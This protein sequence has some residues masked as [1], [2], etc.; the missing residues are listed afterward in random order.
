MAKLTVL[1]T[2]SGAP[3][4]G[5]ACSSYLLEQDGARILLDAG[6]GSLANLRSV[7]EV[8]DID[9]VFITHMHSDHFLDLLPFNVARATAPGQRMTGGAPW[10]TP[11][12]LPP[13]GMATL[14]ACFKALQVNVGGSTAGRW[15][16]IFDTR[17]YDPTETISIGDIDVSF[18]GPTKHAQEDYGF[19]LQLGNGVF[20]YTG[21]TAYCE[22]AI[23][24]GRDAGIFLAECTVLEPGTRVAETHTSVPELAAMANA[25]G[26]ERLLV[27]H[28]SDATENFLQDLEHRLKPLYKKPFTVLRPGDTFEF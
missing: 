3:H 22:A 13:G 12:F 6:P 26:C 14:D 7:A 23:D 4:A 24:V 10:R 11:L 9:A 20:G 1:G 17:E 18:V 19:R 28:F 27:T 21:D 5:G 16:E 8:H 25:S 15:I 2:S